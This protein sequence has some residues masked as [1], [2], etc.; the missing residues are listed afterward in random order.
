[1]S[2]PAGTRSKVLDYADDHE[3][4]GRLG[5]NKEFLTFLELPEELIKFADWFLPDSFSGDTLLSI[6]NQTTEMAQILNRSFEILPPHGWAIPKN[7]N[8]SVLSEVIA[9]LDQERK[10]FAIAE[11]R[12]VEHWNQPGHFEQIVRRVGLIAAGHDQLWA[13]SRDRERLLSDAIRHHRNGDFAAS[14]LMLLTHIDGITCDLTGRSK[15]SFFDSGAAKYYED[16]ESFI[17]ARKSLKGLQ[18]AFTKHYP[19]SAHTGNPSRH[20][21]LHGRELGYD[22]IENSTKLFVLL[23]AIVE[24]SRPRADKLVEASN[25]E[26]ESMYADTREVDEIGRQLDRRGFVVA[27][28]LVDAALHADQMH[29]AVHGRLC[30]EISE[31]RGALKA[32]GHKD[33]DSLRSCHD[34]DLLR[35]WYWV[36]T[37][38]GFCF[39]NGQIVGEDGHWKFAQY[40]EPTDGPPGAD[41][42]R[43][44]SRDPHLVDW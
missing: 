31:L 42:W 41:D 25:A 8:V 34:P 4:L 39:G 3:L 40:G 33:T 37:P 30:Q 7:S 13:V 36:Q 18:R 2:R 10:A 29:F 11:A 14:I 9:I 32:M 17:G 15:G 20:G 23:S 21:I 16:A 22:T 43:H 24:W 19:N 35:A 27:K 12:L 1:M 28:E 44:V 38:S 26:R 6:R 5:A